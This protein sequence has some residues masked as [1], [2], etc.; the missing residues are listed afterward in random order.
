LG[1]CRSLSDPLDSFLQV[2]FDILPLEGF[3]DLFVEVLKFEYSRFEGLRVREV[4]WREDLA[5]QYGEEYLDLVEPTGVYGRV[6]LHGIRIPL[7]QPL[8]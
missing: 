8:R 5:L 3:G 2:I 1:R 4:V 7:R 6:D